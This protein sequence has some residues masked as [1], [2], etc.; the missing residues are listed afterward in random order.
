MDLA[1]ASPSGEVLDAAVD[2]YAEFS[3]L[4]GL[5]FY[6]RQW[7]LAMAIVQAALLGSM[8]VSYSQAKM[9]AMRVDTLRCWMRRPERAVYLGGGAFPSPLITVWIEGADIPRIICCSRRF[10]WLRSSATPPPSI[11]SWPCMRS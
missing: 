1:H 5:C 7:P 10:G 9:E 4:A 8:L 6:Y 11:A 2:R 3:F